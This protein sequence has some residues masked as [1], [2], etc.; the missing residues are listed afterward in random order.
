MN[1]TSLKIKNFCSLKDTVKRVITY[2]QTGRQYLQITYQMKDLY[3]R[4]YKHRS[5]LTTQL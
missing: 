1:Q 5:K 2:A 4:I 3:F